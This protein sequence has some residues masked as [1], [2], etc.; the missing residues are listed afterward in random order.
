M[1]NKLLATKDEFST[2]I[3]RVTLGVVMLPH[4]PR[5]CWD[6][7]VAMVLAEPYHFTENM[8]IPYLVTI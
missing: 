2:T 8:G 5:N 1:L 3:L 7:S 6:G 4:V